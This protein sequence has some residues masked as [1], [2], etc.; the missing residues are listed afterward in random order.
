MSASPVLSVNIFYQRKLNFGIRISFFIFHFI[1]IA[2]FK[3]YNILLFVIVVP[4]VFL[5]RSLRFPFFNK[6]F[7]ASTK[8]TNFIKFTFTIYNFS[9][10]FVCF[11]PS[12]FCRAHNYL[13]LII[14]EKKHEKIVTI[15][16]ATERMKENILAQLVRNG[17]IIN[18]RI[19]PL[20]FFIQK[21]L[22]FSIFSYCKSQLSLFFASSFAPSL[23][24]NFLF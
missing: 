4:A 17:N 9:F 21:F 13:L 7:F 15:K 5:S 22:S 6:F 3:K 2:S 12:I 20:N 23:P 11:Y 14:W 8:R 19:F 10:C 16:M 24:L 18:T 1:T